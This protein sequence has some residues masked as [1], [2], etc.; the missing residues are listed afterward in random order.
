MKALLGKH[1]KEDV[2]FV[3]DIDQYHIE[4]VAAKLLK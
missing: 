4:R 2:I 3:T 1:G